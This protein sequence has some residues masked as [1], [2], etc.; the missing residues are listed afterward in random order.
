ML[1]AYVAMRLTNRNNS[2]TRCSVVIE[3]LK[4]YPNMATTQTPI[5]SAYREWF[6]GFLRRELYV[7]CTAGLVDHLKQ[8]QRLWV[9]PSTE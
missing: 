7:T 9:L 2:Q 3:T 5:G 8:H 1:Q 6:Q 4:K